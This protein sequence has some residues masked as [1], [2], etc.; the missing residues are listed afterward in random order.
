M[1]SL[2]D[3]KFIDNYCWLNEPFCVNNNRIFNQFEITL[4]NWLKLEIDNVIKFYPPTIKDILMLGDTVYSEILYI[5]KYSKECIEDINEINKIKKIGTKNYMYLKHGSDYNKLI[6]QLFSIIFKTIDIQIGEDEGDL[7][8]RINQDGK[9][10]TIDS[11]NYDFIID[12]ILYMLCESKFTKEDLKPK[13]ENKNPLF[14]KIKKIRDKR[15]RKEALDMLK[16]EEERKRED[17]EIEMLSSSWVSWYLNVVH[18]DNNVD[19]E[20]KKNMTLR[21]LYIS[22]SYLRLKDDNSY[23]RNIASNGMLKED[24][25]LDTSFVGWQ[26]VEKILKPNYKGNNK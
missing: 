24:S 14:E 23:I 22:I 21:Q 8:F 10:F 3:R 9:G 2:E 7:V 20:K 11:N 1:L 5:I 13:K 25:K 4:S 12:V 15:M 17:K 26:F 18:L 16:K 19:Y 6:I